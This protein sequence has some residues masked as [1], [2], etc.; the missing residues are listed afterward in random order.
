MSHTGMSNWNLKGL[1]KNFETDLFYPEPGESEKSKKACSVCKNC[2]VRAECL[3]EALENSEQ[4]GIWG[5]FTLR[6]RRK[7][8]SHLRGRLS[9]DEVRRFIEI[10]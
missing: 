10:E 5:G 7:I 1:C 9:I 6:Q 8:L 4:F 2:P 3:T